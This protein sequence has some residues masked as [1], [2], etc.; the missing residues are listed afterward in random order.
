MGH[1]RRKALFSV[2]TCVAVAM[3]L[4]LG[5]FTWLDYSIAAA[6]GMSSSPAPVEVGIYNFYFDPSIVTVTM[7]TT[8]VWHN[9]AP[10]TSH[11]VNINGVGDSGAIAGGGTYSHTFNALGTFAYH[12]SFHPSMQGEVRVRSYLYLPLILSSGP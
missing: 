3:G 1:D 10:N 4:L 6:T 5:A 12:C 2:G 8:V 11:T 7:G 9:N